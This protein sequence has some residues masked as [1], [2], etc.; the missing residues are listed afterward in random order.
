MV[1]LEVGLE[2]LQVLRVELLEV[3]ELL[4]DSAAEAAGSTTGWAGGWTSASARPGGSEP[5]CW[6]WSPLAAAS[7]GWGTQSADI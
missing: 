3:E 2:G 6:L 4:P 5:G 7:C 1:S